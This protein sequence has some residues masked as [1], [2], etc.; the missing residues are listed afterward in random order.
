MYSLGNFIFDQY[1]SVPTQRA[2]AVHYVLDTNQQTATIVPIR[3]EK[4]QPTKVIGEV[5]DQILRQVGLDSD[6]ITIP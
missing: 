1:W 6:I 5:R 2:I 4:A 3:L